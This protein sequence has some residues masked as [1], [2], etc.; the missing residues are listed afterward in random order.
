MKRWLYEKISEIDK[1][2]DFLTERSNKMA[3]EYDD[4]MAVVVAERAQYVAL[5]SAFDAQ[6][7]ILN[8]HIAQLQDA[9]TNPTVGGIVITPEQFSA[10]KDAVEGIVPDQAP[11]V[12]PVVSDPVPVADPAPVDVPADTAP[13]D[14]GAVVSVDTAPVDGTAVA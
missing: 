1:R 6:T 2:L 3:G 4:L 9:G 12:D 5:Q 10:L 13:A 11:A 7:A 8:A 14:T